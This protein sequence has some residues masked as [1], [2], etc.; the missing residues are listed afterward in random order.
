MLSKTLLPFAFVCIV[1]LEVNA[2]PERFSNGKPGKYRFE[3]HLPEKTY[4]L[5][6]AM[7][8][9]TE[10][11]AF[12]KNVA[13]VAAWFQQNH[14]MIMHPTGYDMRTLTTWIWGDF[15][16]VAKWEYGIPAELSFLFELLY[17]DGS[18]W[19]IEPP[20]AKLLINHVSGGHDGWYFTPESVVEDG[21][22]YDLLK[23]G[24]V[25]KALEQLQSYFMVYQ[26]KSEMAPGVHEFEAYPGGRKTIVV[27]NPERPPYWIPVTVK[28]ITDAQ[29]A[30][31]SLFTKQ[32]LD[33]MVLDELKKEIAGLSSEEL[34]ASAYSGHE[35][36]FVLKVNGRGQGLQIMKFNPD[37]WN[38]SL[39]KQAIQFITFWSSGY[40]DEQKA[41]DMNGRGYPEYPLMFVNQVNWAGVAGLIMK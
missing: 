35:S 18:K 1:S 36:N 2:Q 20:Q 41:E 6:N 31:Y 8:S 19:S 14:P 9:S 24:D 3:S 29:L 40:T 32:E 33:R 4:S 5:R 39:P 38:R 28:E 21:T 7:L 27:F 16:T 11:I 15:S 30:Y 12:K 10:N 25:K 17:T 22:R 34:A 26:F 23:S 37:Y 13:E